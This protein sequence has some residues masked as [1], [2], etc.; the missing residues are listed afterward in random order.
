MD[1]I[2]MYRS[3]SMITLVI[4]CKKLKVVFRSMSLFMLFF[5]Y[6]NI[7]TSNKKIY[8]HQAYIYMLWYTWE[9]KM[10]I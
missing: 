1:S 7:Y 4:E 10:Y 5:F 9:Q 2:E 8:N 3:L 6:I